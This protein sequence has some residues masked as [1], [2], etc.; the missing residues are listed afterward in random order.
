MRRIGAALLAVILAFS[1][2]VAAFAAPDDPAGNPEVQDVQTDEL[3]ETAD[4][5]VGAS[6][7]ALPE[8]SAFDNPE[9]AAVDEAAEDLPETHPE[10]LPEELLEDTPEEL[11]EELPEEEGAFEALAATEGNFEYEISG[12]KATISNYYGSGGALTIPSKLGG[13]PVTAIGAYAFNGSAIT[14]LTLPSTVTSIGEFAFNDNRKLKTINWSANLKSIDDNA[15]SFCS[16]L[17]TLSLPSKLETVGA[18]A[19]DE[20]SAVTSLTIPASLTS[21]GYGAFADMCKLTTINY[22]A[23]NATFQ[24]ATFNN[25]GKSSASLTL[26]VGSGVTKVPECLFYSTGDN[27]VRLT[28]LKLSDSVTEIGNSAFINCEDLKKIAWSSNLDRI[29]QYAFYCCESLPSLSFP[30]SL[31]TI[32]QRAF[33]KAYSL[34]QVT[35]PKNLQS[36][37]YSFI[38]CSKLK[39]VI[40]YGNTN[41]SQNEFVNSA[42]GFT[43]YCYKNT[44]IDTYAQSKGFKIVYLTRNS[45]FPDVPPY[46]AYQKAVYWCAD[47]NIAAGY[48]N[49]YFGINDEVTRGQVVMFLWRLAGKP[50]PMMTTQT[51]KDVKTTHNFYKAIQWA[52]EEGITGGY[53]GKKA[54]YFGVNDSC[55]R[56]QIVTFL[57]RYKNK[58]N[59]G[60]LTPKFSDVPKSHNFFKAVQWAANCGITEGYSDGTFGVNKTCTRGH[61]VTFIYRMVLYYAAG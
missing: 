36:V 4:S 46:H 21:I 1:V 18:Y 43:V 19:F 51:F 42:S 53:T 35:F 28:E 33:E 50:E 13:A 56:G 59:P 25:A 57:W 38:D 45:Y 16:S 41:F 34:T 9:K 7:T 47:N 31:K 39:R 55:T 29:G 12:G 8:V 27:Y 3:V 44:Q 30:D 58:P 61:C 2:S 14:S 11:P 15:F 37:Q 17:T 40:V 32:E 6:D 23:T 26:T 48:N 20:T 49:G 52:Y 60:N 5:L 10:E 22:N 54:G 24:S